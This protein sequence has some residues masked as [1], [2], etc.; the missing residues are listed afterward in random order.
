M[1]GLLEAHT[2]VEGL[3]SDCIVVYVLKTYFVLRANCIRGVQMKLDILQ[4]PINCMIEDS[5]LQVLPKWSPDD[6]YRYIYK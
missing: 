5:K 3:Y 6:S 4:Q 2:C 1:F